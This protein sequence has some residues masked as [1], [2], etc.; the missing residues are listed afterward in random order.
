VTPSA[1]WAACVLAAVGLAAVVRDSA[2]LR[3]P[4]AWVARSPR[5]A[6]F[7]RCWLCLGWWAG[8][9]AA[10]AIG[11]RGPSLLAAPFA[12][13]AVAYLAGAWLASV[14]IEDTE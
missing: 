8:W 5:G 4:R 13:A 3:R 7:M 11:L 2:L 9:P 10:V 1:Q 6:Q 14:Q 12:T